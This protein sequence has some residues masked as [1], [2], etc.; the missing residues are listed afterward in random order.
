M[1]IDQT[2]RTHNIYSIKAPKIEWLNYFNKGLI[3]ES[4]NNNINTEENPKNKLFIDPKYN[5]KSNIFNN[6]QEINEQLKS[7][8]LNNEFSL[9]A[10][11]IYFSN[12]T[13]KSNTHKNSINNF[14]KQN[15][16]FTLEKEDIT[17]YEPSNYNNT[18]NNY[19]LRSNN[20]QKNNINKKI[21]PDNSSLF[22]FKDSYDYPI[23]E[24][25]QFPSSYCMLYKKKK[26]MKINDVDGYNNNL[27]KKEGDINKNTQDIFINRTLPQMRVLSNYGLVSDEDYEMYENVQRNNLMNKAINNAKNGELVH[28]YNFNNNGIFLKDKDRK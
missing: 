9:D 1:Q 23:N 2:A 18:N 4:I 11:S 20:K 16:I 6:P 22:G 3:T 24:L 27:Y 5:I 21:T 25:R 12:S 14:I 15:K 19:T 13:N 17:S 8:S 28:I 10:N 26:N 7:R